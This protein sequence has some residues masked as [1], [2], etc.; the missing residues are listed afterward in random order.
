MVGV[1][2]MLRSKTESYFSPFRYLN[3]PTHGCI[4]Q[5]LITNH[6]LYVT[7]THHIIL[8]SDIDVVIKIDQRFFFKLKS[9]MVTAI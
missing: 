9:R 5:N 2:I 8:S 1:R 6:F 4:N 3:L 7:I